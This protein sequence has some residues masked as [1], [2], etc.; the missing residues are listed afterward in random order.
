MWATMSIALGCSVLFA[1]AGRW[2]IRV[3]ASQAAVPTEG[4]M[5]LM[6]VWVLI[7]TFMNNTATVLVA[8]GKT[9]LIAWCGLASAAMNLAL[10][11]IWVQRIGAPGVI[12]G[13][14]V[15]YLVIVVVPQTWKA[16]S[17]LADDLSPRQEA[18]QPQC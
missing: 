17:V 3:W 9:R 15:S 11:I 12:L 18:A 10:S 14:I 1:L 8:K 16:Y 7:S 13:T 4:L 2:I 5:L 6:C